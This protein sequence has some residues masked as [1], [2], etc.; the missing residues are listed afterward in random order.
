MACAVF[1]PLSVASADT[2][3]AVIRIA[4]SIQEQVRR[5]LLRVSS[6]H[7]LSPGPATL[8]VALILGERSVEPSAVGDGGP[9]F[10]FHGEGAGAR[11]SG[12]GLPG[13]AVA[14]VLDEERRREDVAGAGRIDLVRR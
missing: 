6:T 4:R 1:E 3:P 5:G 8:V 11:G 12:G 2:L 7:P 14:L 10:A 13:I 9:A